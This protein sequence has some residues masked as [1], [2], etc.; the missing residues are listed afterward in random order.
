MQIFSDQSVK[1]VCMELAKCGISA[2]AVATLFLVS[3]SVCGVALL[4]RKMPA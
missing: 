1:T 2:G 3:T 4:S